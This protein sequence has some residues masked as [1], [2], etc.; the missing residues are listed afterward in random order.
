MNT[1]NCR[2]AVAAWLAVA[3]FSSTLTA[4][5]GV[6]EVGVET[7]L[8]AD[9]AATVV[10]L[11]TENA[12]L[13]ALLATRQATPTLAG[14]VSPTPV[15]ISTA[16]PI[17]TMGVKAVAGSPPG[18]RLNQLL[19]EYE[20]ISLG[21][22]SPDGTHLVLYT[23]AGPLE[24]EQIP[25][26]EP[27]IVDVESGAAWRTGDGGPYP[28]QDWFAWLP[29]GDALF[30]AGGELWRAQADGQD[31]RL[32]T[33]AVADTI[34]AFTP[35]PDGGTVLT[36]GE[37][38]Y[39]LIPTDG[40]VPRAVTDLPGGSGGWSWSPDGTQIAL[41]HE[42]GTTYLVDL[43]S[44]TAH[45]LAETPVVGGWPV[46]PVWLANGQLFLNAPVYPYNRP[47][48][49][50][51]ESSDVR[52]LVS[53]LGLPEPEHIISRYYPS[54]DGM[55]MAINVADLDK[56]ANMN[57]LWNIVTDELTE[58]G[59]PVGVFA[60][61]WSPTGKQIEVL[62]GEGDEEVLA[63]L[64]ASSGEVHR[65][66]EP[67]WPPTAWTPDGTRITFASPEGEVWVVPA[68][69]SSSAKLLM[70]SLGDNPVPQW[71]P[72]GCRL[73][74]AVEH[75][76]GSFYGELY[77]VELVSVTEE[78]PAPAG[79]EGQLAL[80]IGGPPLSLVNL[81]GGAPRTL[82][83]ENMATYGA[84]FFQWSPNGREIVYSADA[85]L[86][87]LDAESGERQNL[88]NNDRWDL[89]P[90]W[91][92]DGDW[93]VFTSRPLLP[94]ESKTG[95]GEGAWGGALVVIGA[96]GADFR[97]LDDEGNVM[98]TPSWAPTG[99]R[100]AYAADG[101]L[102]LYDL[103]T[104]ER[105]V[106]AP[107]DF[108]LDVAYLDGPAW[109]PDGRLIAAYFSHSAEFAEWDAL[110]AGTAPDVGQ[111]VV[112]LDPKTHTANVLFEWEAP[113]VGAIPVL[114]WQP[115]GDL[116]LIDVRAAPRVPQQAG[117]WLADPATG[118]VTALPVAA[119]DADWSPDGRWI[120]AIDLDDRERLVLVNVEH[121]TA[122]PA[123]HR[124]PYGLEGLAWRP[125][126]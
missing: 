71:S 70:P 68:D 126:P 34:I 54:P 93:I 99:R 8:T 119:Y 10:A 91:S 96:N 84:L 35:S 121:P 20:G 3:L 5:G 73:A 23:P 50:D 42:N 36:R 78:T 47:A 80:L 33:E 98:A 38:Q 27:M 103:D 66:A 1:M 25:D 40:G 37:R 61:L 120:A 52:D 9:A 76:F 112:L 79:P 13:R 106:L 89:M 111:G 118:K 60:G 115:G 83:A 4:C 87:L 63:V 11:A 12:R 123:V 43:A 100:L 14:T 122:E 30:V 48:L 94:N 82:G 15:A 104:G 31:R 107:S 105:S 39:W 77:V 16:G 86:W 19:H 26:A 74:V 28:Y 58:V 32:L 90:T 41:W 101:E 44:A 62:L 88:T 67:A 64:D 102:R 117:L 95:W 29:N 69:G 85:D 46:A 65:L 113:F 45:A 110:G 51:L 124:W 7:T 97:I 75:R 57:Y 56:F 59:P 114:R 109:S 22:W 108:N 92:L 125:L 55:Y 2:K 49:V 21:D 53:T 24:G 116:L 81:A 72:D 18:T 17:F 6:L